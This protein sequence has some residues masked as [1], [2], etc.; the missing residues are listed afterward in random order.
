VAGCAGAGVCGCVCGS[1]ALA[2]IHTL[3]C[4]AHTHTHTH[5]QT[6]T[7]TRTHK[8]THTH[9]HSHRHTHTHTHTHTHAVYFV[10]GI[11]GLSRLALSFFFKDD[12]GI[13]PAEVWLRSGACWCD[14]AHAAASQRLQHPPAAVCAGGLRL[15]M[16]ALSP[17]TPPPPNAAARAPCHTL[18]SHHHTTSHTHTRRWRC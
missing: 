2:C 1:C 4:C 5:T 16:T 15:D 3:L 13:E 18:R 12:L 11:L 10:Q 8:H 7:H 14:G 6:H 9:T 17:L